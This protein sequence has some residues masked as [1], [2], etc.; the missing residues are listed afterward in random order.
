MD[1]IKGHILNADFEA[2]KI[3][4]AKG[5]PEIKV[6]MHDVANGASNT[7]VCGLGEPPAIPTAAAV[8]GAIHN[9]I[10]V[11][12][13]DMPFTPDKILEALA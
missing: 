2:Y 6:V 8:G 10:G 11:R 1:R 7:P 5:M 9:A 4:G 3:L 13:T 12:V